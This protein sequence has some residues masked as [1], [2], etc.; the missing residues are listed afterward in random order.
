ML[1]PQC[2]TENREGRRFWNLE[3]V[4]DPQCSSLGR[5]VVHAESA[6]DLEKLLPPV[7]VYRNVLDVDG[8]MLDVCLL[9]QDRRKS[10]SNCLGS[11]MGRVGQDVVG[12]SRTR[13]L[14]VQGVVGLV[15]DVPSVT[16]LPKLEGAREKDARRILL[17]A[18][19]Q[20][21]GCAGED[22]V[23]FLRLSHDLACSFA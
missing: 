15:T 23:V 13:Q 22:D 6:R 8:E 14:D 2:H 18:V 9:G 1:C 4:P 3:V 17:T 10:P 19:H 12:R 21:A 5:L 16:R 11:R 7:G 20:E